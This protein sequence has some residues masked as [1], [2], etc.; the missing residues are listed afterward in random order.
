[1]VSF[2][3]R[4]Q[5]PSRDH[6][7]QHLTEYKKHYEI[8]PVHRPVEVTSVSR[9]GAG[10]LVSTDEGEW[11]ANAVVNATGKWGCSYILG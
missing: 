2:D 3:Y 9:L 4:G 6:V 7:L 8:P 10:L 11:L 1:M 5:Y